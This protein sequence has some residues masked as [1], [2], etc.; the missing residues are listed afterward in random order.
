MARCG[1][2]VYVCAWLRPAFTDVL[3]TLPFLGQDDLIIKV[4]ES[5]A[6]VSRHKDRLPMQLEQIPGAGHLLVDDP[7]EV[8]AWLRKL[9]G[10]PVAPPEP[11]QPQKQQPKPEQTH[12]EAAANTDP[13]ASAPTAAAQS[14]VR[15]RKARPRRDL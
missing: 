9:R 2:C 4:K 12:K 14:G 7:K 13:A 5:I 3:P 15:R 1:G 8:K 11:K 6:L 10:M